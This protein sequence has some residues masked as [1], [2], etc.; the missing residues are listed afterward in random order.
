[1]F[2]VTILIQH[3]V[4][5]SSY[6][7]EAGKR[8]KSHTNWKRGN[9]TIFCYR[10]RDFPHL[11]I[12]CLA[13]TGC[14]GRTVSPLVLRGPLQ[15]AGTGPESTAWAWQTRWTPTPPFPAVHL[16]ALPLTSLDFGPLI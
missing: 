7:D 10:Q 4:G 16:W 12:S 5:G 15:Q 8:K 6:C 14:V 2:A 9:K 1:M 13:F 3:S 11:E